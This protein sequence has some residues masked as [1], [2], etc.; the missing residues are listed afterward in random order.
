MASLHISVNK[1]PPCRR[2]PDCREQ[3]V[4]V[5]P[6]CTTQPHIRHHTTHSHIYTM[7]DNLLHT[8]T[9]YCT[10]CHTTTLTLD[11]IPPVHTFV[12][13]AHNKTTQPHVYRATYNLTLIVHRR[14]PQVTTNLRSPLHQDESVI[15]GASER[16]VQ[17]GNVRQDFNKY[18][19]CKIT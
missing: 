19:F 18:D 1:F 8:S 4:G 12:D 6:C 16:L 2:L 14:L 3:K 15:Q 13:G 7:M 11:P 17:T 9:L 10:S 5:H